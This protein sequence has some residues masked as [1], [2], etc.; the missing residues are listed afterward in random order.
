V[1]RWEEGSLVKTEREQK[2]LATSSMVGRKILST[3][4]GWRRWRQGRGNLD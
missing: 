3:V 2:V 1:S 4:R